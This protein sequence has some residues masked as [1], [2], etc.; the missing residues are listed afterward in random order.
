MI[1][2]LMFSAPGL[3]A[4]S[5][6]SSEDLFQ[7]ARRLAF[8]DK[9]YPDAIALTKQ[10]LTISPDYADIRIFLGSLYTWTDKVDSARTEFKKVLEKNR[11]SRGRWKRELR[12]IWWG[13]GLSSKAP[14]AG[15]WS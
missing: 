12:T 15:L 13:Q 5:Q 1:I 3:L 4:Q 11:P 7:N 8:D 10:A 14:S 6:L 9:N 2:G